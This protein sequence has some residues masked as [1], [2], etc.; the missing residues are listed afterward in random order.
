MAKNYSENPE[1]NIL[2]HDIVAKEAAAMLVEESQFI[3][4]INR[5]REKEFA[6]DKGGYKVGD[7]V[8]IRV[9]PTPMRGT[10]LTKK[11][12]TKT[13]K[14]PLFC[15]KSTPNDMLD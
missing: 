15:S 11:M 6:K 2:T 3:K 5:N 1:N 13:L 12:Q 8:R 14:K 10:S 4:A 9:P 7:S